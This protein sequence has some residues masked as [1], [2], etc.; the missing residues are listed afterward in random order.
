MYLWIW[1]RTVL[2]LYQIKYQINTDVYKHKRLS[3]QTTDFVCLII[4]F[5][6]LEKKRNYC[7]VAHCDCS[8]H[9]V[10]GPY[11]YGYDHLCTYSYWW[12][13]HTRMVRLINMINIEKVSHKL[14]V[15]KM[16]FLPVLSSASQWKMINF[17][18]LILYTTFYKLE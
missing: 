17:I 4:E 8:G 2:I 10:F 16:K 14:R 12:T 1:M 7:I 15:S 11:G 9:W 5:Y 3:C 18:K 6:Y 13:D